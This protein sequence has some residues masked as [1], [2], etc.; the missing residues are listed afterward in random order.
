MIQCNQF[1]DR[2]KEKGRRQRTNSSCAWMSFQLDNTHEKNRNEQH[3]DSFIYSASR[4]MIGMF[5]TSYTRILRAIIIWLTSNN[6]LS[7]HSLIHRVVYLFMYQHNLHCPALMVDCVT[8]FILDLDST[9]EIL[10]TWDHREMRQDCRLSA[11]FSDGMSRTDPTL[12]LVQWPLGPLYALVIEA[13]SPD[14]WSL[15]FSSA[16]F[17]YESIIKPFFFSIV[18]KFCF[19][20]LE[21]SLFFVVS[22][23]TRVS[24][25]LMIFF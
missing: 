14:S 16:R 12:S 3:V 19:K 20:V 21:F 10:T 23:L 4:Q 6:I 24:L 17:T 7:I 2:I 8:T 1:S 25:F 22:D 11:L 18:S 5:S 15:Q 13:F 9:R